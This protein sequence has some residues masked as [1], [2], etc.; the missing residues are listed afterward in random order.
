MLILAS[1]SKYRRKILK[2]FGLRFSAK[3]AAVNEDEL[4]NRYH[5]KNKGPK[6]IKYFSDLAI[7]LAEHKAH[8][9]AKDLSLKK[10]AYIIGSDQIAVFNQ[11]S[12]NK[13][14]T[15]K[16]AFLQLKKMRGKTHFLVTSVC[17]IKKTS[18]IFRF[19]SGVVVAEIKMR[20]YSNQEIHNTLKK[21][22][23]FDCAGAYKIEKS[24]LQLIEK[25]KVDDFSSIVGLPLIK[26]YKYLTDLGYKSER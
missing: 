3:T 20:N 21:D 19:Q 11:T 4:K 17:I 24:G 14:K 18:E 7:Y 22:A 23:P 1:R 10:N 16:K 26:T 8:A 25:V 2:D 6:G 5:K 15:Y 13:P 9:V 12:L